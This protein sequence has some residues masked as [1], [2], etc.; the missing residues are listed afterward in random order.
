MQHGS[1]GSK[2]E[3]IQSAEEARAVDPAERPPA[4]FQTKSPP[5][6]PPPPTGSPAAACVNPPHPHPS[7]LCSAFSRHLTPP[8][9]FMNTLEDSAIGVGHLALHRVV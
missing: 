7:A 6:S 9:L 1:W 3:F 4:P 2:T 5:C 8:G